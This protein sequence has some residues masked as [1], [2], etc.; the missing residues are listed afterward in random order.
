MIIDS[1]TPDQG[2][3]AIG[4]RPCDYVTTFLLAELHFG[5]K[6]GGDDVPDE[7]QPT[8]QKSGTPIMLGIARRPLLPPLSAVCVSPSPSYRKIP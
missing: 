1:A 8:C 7:P 5:E 6:R 4:M 3:Q 2:T